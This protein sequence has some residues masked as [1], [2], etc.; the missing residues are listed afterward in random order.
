M[1]SDGF[2][3][4]V[5]PRHPDLRRLLDYWRAKCGDRRFP[6]RADIDPIDFS[7]M[8]ERI[9]LTEVHLGER[10]FRLRVVGSWWSGLV[11]FESTGMWMDDWPHA[12]Q[13]QLT[14]DTYD[15]LIAARRPLVA[16]RRAWV[17]DRKLDYEI[18]LLP[19]SEDGDRISM[20]MTAI[21]PS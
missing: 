8:L 10:R 14:V 7:F 17:D 2:D 12:N 21:G 5:P 11:G 20:I 9:A 15:S 13:R 18:M 19:L 1:T 4:R 16:V 6:R 3:D